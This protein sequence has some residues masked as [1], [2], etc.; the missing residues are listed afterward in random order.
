M[1][2]LVND[3]AKNDFWR[4]TRF[5]QIVRFLA[6]KDDYGVLMTDIAT[7]LSVSKNLVSRTMK[8]RRNPSETPSKPGRPSAIREVFHRV[9][10]FIDTENAAGRA[11]T[12]GVLM[13]FVTDTLK[14]TVSRKTLWRYVKGNG[15]L[16]KMAE[17]RDIEHTTPHPDAIAAYYNSLAAELADVHP[18]LV[19]NMDEMGM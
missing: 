2:A 1:M 4:V 15:F 12:M 6:V 11:V 17:A 10:N 9:E 7:T 18:S 13:S 5:V 16:Y 3:V 8:F 19:F 14:I